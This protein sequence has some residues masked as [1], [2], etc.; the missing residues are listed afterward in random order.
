M[1][2]G[3]PRPGSPLQAGGVFAEATMLWKEEAKHPREQDRDLVGVLAE[4]SLQTRPAP[5]ASLCHAMTSMMNL[6][7][8][9][10]QGPQFP[11]RKL[12]AQEVK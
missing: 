4:R 3:W 2:V 6:Q 12:R 11:L 10:H 5:A 8:R 1:Q 9:R 7:K